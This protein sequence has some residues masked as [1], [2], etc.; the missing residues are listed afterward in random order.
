MGT[1]WKPDGGWGWGASAP[2]LGTH[3]PLPLSG[4]SRGGRVTA[5]RARPLLPAQSGQGPGWSLGHQSPGGAAP[6]RPSPTCRSARRLLLLSAC[7]PVAGSCGEPGRGQEIIGLSQLHPPPSHPHPAS[8][9]GEAEAREA[10]RRPSRQVCW[11]PGRRA[12]PTRGRRARRGQA[13]PQ[14][15]PPQPWLKEAAR[16]EAL[17]LGAEGHRAVPTPPHPGRPAKRGGL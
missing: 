7:P 16:R 2:S 17:P 13:S 8:G 15:R 6:A 12:S 3:W 1:A 11:P 5:D 10:T 9:E 14:P 4:L